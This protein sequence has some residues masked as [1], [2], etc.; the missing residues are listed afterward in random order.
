[1]IFVSRENKFW[2]GGK[3]LIYASLDQY[4]VLTY[5]LSSDRQNNK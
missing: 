4:S 5:Q 1:M 2:F 3:T